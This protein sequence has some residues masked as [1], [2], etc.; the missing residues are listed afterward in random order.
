M[1]Q[2]CKDDAVD[3]GNA[4]IAAIRRLIGE[5][6]NSNLSARPASVPEECCQRVDVAIARR[7]G[8]P[9]PT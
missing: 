4:H 9:R 5:L 6:A 2:P 3:D 1:V 7:A 8:C